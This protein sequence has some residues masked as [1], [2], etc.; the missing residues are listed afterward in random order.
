MSS[1][2]LDKY[3]A[4]INQGYLENKLKMI[5]TSVKET[6]SSMV[7]D[8]PVLIS[9]E[10]IADDHVMLGVE[11]APDGSAVKAYT[12]DAN[13]K[14][15]DITKAEPE[16]KAQYEEYSLRDVISEHLQKIANMKEEQKEVATPQP[17]EHKVRRTEVSKETASYIKSRGTNRQS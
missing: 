15:I 3:T 2:K 1:K 6:Y 11:Y 16:K 12:T 14:H 4:L 9:R 5:P 10:L 17:V 7:E 13:G 8:H